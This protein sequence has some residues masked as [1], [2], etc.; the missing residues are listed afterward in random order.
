MKKELVGILACPVCK[1]SL[2][3]TIKEEDTSGEVLEGSLYC[4]MC[5]HNY[6]IKEGIPNLLPP[7]LDRKD[8]A[9]L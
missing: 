2:E 8:N 6:P 9:P 1:V 5:G 7:S 4:R 3:L